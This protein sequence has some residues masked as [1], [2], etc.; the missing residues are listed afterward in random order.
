MQWFTIDVNLS[1]L[2]WTC[3][4]LNWRKYVIILWKLYVVLFTIYVVIIWSGL[5]SMIPMPSL[6]SFSLNIFHS[7]G[8]NQF[9]HLY[10]NIYFRH[11]LV[12]TRFDL[13]YIF[14]HVLNFITDMS[15]LISY[16]VIWD[17]GVNEINVFIEHFINQRWKINIIYMKYFDTK[18]ILILNSFNS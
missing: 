8:T 14:R 7:S 16:I 4:P 11:L 9:N 6:N 2:E 3:F 17:Y 12:G 1:H 13:H 15:L 18:W 5:Q 10:W